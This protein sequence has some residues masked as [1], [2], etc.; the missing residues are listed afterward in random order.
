MKIRDLD[1]LVYSPWKVYPP[2]PVTP[3]SHL[4]LLNLLHQ[5]SSDIF[6]RIHWNEFLIYYFNFELISFDFKCMFSSSAA[7]H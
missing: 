3:R 1:L 4:A 5:V 6:A 2:S 7:S